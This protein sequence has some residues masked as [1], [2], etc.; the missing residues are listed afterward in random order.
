[1]T[2]TSGWVLETIG[3]L[4]L[5]VMALVTWPVAAGDDQGIILA[6]I[7]GLRRDGIDVDAAGPRR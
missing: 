5:R 1:M 2:V 3:E 4:E 7:V 6:D